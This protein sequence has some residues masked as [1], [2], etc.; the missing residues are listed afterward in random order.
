[1]Y[2]T[3]VGF[4]FP[5]P[6]ITYHDALLNSAR[7]MKLDMLHCSPQCGI[8]SYIPKE[9]DTGG[10]CF[11]ALTM[12]NDLPSHNYDAFLRD[13]TL[14]DREVSLVGQLVVKKSFVLLAKQV[15]VDAI[16]AW[17]H[18]YQVDLVMSE[19]TVP[20]SPGPTILCGP[21]EI[22]YVSQ[23]MR[24]RPPKQYSEH[25]VQEIALLTM[26]QLIARMDCAPLDLPVYP[27]AWS[28][29]PQCE[30]TFEVLESPADG[31]SDDEYEMEASNQFT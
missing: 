31:L 7:W 10:A 4:R 17:D 14:P 26:D 8:G 25:C 21:C 22:K 23:S 3:R 5:H 2:P 11:A 18:C 20:W 1:M 15:G 9:W 28:I 29:G 19:R 12:H 24:F 13:G 6:L 27:G 16:G 30:T